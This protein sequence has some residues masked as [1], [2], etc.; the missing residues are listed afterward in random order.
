MLT[1]LTS[2]SLG[3]EVA[4]RLDV[5]RGATESNRISDNQVTGNSDSS[6]DSTRFVESTK[7]AGAYAVLRSRQDEL[8]DVATVVHDVNSVTDK[9]EQLLGEMESK[10]G[11]LVKIYPPYP[12]DNPERVSMLNSFAGLRKQIDALTFPSPDE[13]G[14]IGRLPTLHGG[15]S[16][17]GKPNTP[18]ELNSAAGNGEIKLPMFDIPDLDSSTASDVEVAQT[19]EKVVAAKDAIQE[20][21]SRIWKDVETFLGRAANSEVQSVAENARHRLAQVNGLGIGVYSG[22]FSQ[23]TEM[24]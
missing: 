18:A 16:E 1:D 23:A 15:G 13:L 14:A 20:L 7:M 8:N 22:Q 6:S 4:K 24:A 9:A 10:L 5:V 11:T 3:Y 2:V 21:Q 19:Y 17:I 12:L